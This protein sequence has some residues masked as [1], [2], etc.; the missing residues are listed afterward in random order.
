MIWDG[1][2]QDTIDKVRTKASVVVI[3]LRLG[4][5]WCC[6]IGEFVAARASVVVKDWLVCCG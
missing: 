5:W 3:A 1:S 6:R 2:G 4:Y